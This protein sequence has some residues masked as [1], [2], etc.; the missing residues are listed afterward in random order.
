MIDS[1]A[2]ISPH[3]EIA[4]DVEVGAFSVIGAGVVIGAGT[5]IGP[6]VVINGPTRIGT[7]N[8][9]FQFASLGDAPQDKK[10]KGE[11]TRLE[12][13]DR[14]VIRE[15]ATVNRGTIQ[16]EG[17]TRIGDD[18]LL[19]AYSHV[20]HDCRVGNQ[21]V[22]SNVATLGGHVEIGDFAI[23]GGLSAVHQFTKVGAYCFIANNAAVTRDVP[24]YV[25]AVGQPAEPHSVNAVGLKRRGFSDEQIL[26][27]RRAYRVLYRSGLKLKA[28]LEQLD[29]AAESQAEIRP[30]VDFIRRSSRSIVR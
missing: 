2:V 17:V 18:N 6:H 22:L 7:G 9:I 13:G 24:P 25:M 27:V 14:N 3:A 8:K 20:A 1:R 10:Y 28:A 15:C 23:L 29:K 4:A 30:F 26:N 16:G 5:W 19:M 21:I 11:P 12:I